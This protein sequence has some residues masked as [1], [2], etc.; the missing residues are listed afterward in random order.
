[1]ASATARPSKA[2]AFGTPIRTGE[3]VALSA[4]AKDPTTFRG[5][6]IATSGTVKAVCQ[7][8]G[9]WM[10]IV[11]DQGHANVRMHGHSFFIPKNASGRR[12]RVEATVV[13]VKDGHECD[14]MAATGAQ[15]ELDATGVELL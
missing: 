5:K 6:S 8:R 9:C 13:L 3:T 7:E 14:E 15:L 2:E 4:I 1:M 10:E 11:D 12:A